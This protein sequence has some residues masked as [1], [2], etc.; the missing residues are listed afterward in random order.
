[1]NRLLLLCYIIYIE[2][3]Q[4]FLSSTL[5]A[6]YLP[7]KY[8]FHDHQLYNNHHRHHQ[9]LKKYYFNRQDEYNNKSN[10]KI[11][12]NKQRHT[13]L[14]NKYTYDNDD[15]I[16]NIVDRRTVH[17]IISCLCKEKLFRIF[18]IPTSLSLTIKTD[19]VYATDNDG[20]SFH[21]PIHL[22]SLPSLPALIKI[23]SLSSMPYLPSLSKSSR[24]SPFS[25]SSPFSSIVTT[26]TTTSTTTT[27]STIMQ[28]IMD[29]VHQFIE[30]LH[31]TNINSNDETPSILSPD[32]IISTFE[33]KQIQI[34]IMNIFNS[35]LQKFLSLSWLLPFHESIETLVFGTIFALLF[36]SILSTITKV[37]TLI[38]IFLDIIIG[39]YMYVYTF[40]LY[41]VDQ[42]K[43]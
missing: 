10:N 29:K 41:I 8:V 36:N 5:R 20:L 32:I 37:I 15:V 19:E 25:S 9:I 28:S 3:H 11:K 23:P 26:T 7:K 6:K 24:L 27:A 17:Y 40:R 35:I 12:S 21:L 38:I 4:L 13:I 30:S 14:Y 31:I 42:I 33:F 2:T 22:P 1:M 34:I 39:I 18:V 16:N 43:Q